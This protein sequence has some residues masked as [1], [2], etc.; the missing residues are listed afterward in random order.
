VACVGATVLELEVEG[1]EV[2][3]ACV[4]AAVLSNATEIEPMDKSDTARPAEE[5]DDM[6]EEVLLE[7]VKVLFTESDF[8]DDKPETT[9]LRLVLVRPRE[10]RLR[11]RRLVLI[12]III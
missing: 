12:V 10:R 2:I 3:V 8:D 9:T 4:G 5:K 1:I 7:S 6:K 11:S